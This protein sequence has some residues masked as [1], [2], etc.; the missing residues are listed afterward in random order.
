MLDLKFVRENLDAVEV[1]MKNRKAD[2]D[3]V[4]FSE[5]DTSR[6]ELIGKEEALQAKRNSDSKQIGAMMKE[7]KKQDAEA[8]K[9]SVRKLN[10]ELETISAE[11]E[12]VDAE[13]TDP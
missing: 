10:E 13:I 9:E 6:R 11:R 7:G 2:F 4:R 8:L 3:K 5:L 12:K 1:A